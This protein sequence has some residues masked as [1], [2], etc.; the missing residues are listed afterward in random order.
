MD[1]GCAVP[2]LRPGFSETFASKLFT[3]ASVRCGPEAA[4]ACDAFAPSCRWAISAEAISAFKLVLNAFLFAELSAGNNKAARTARMAITINSSMSVNARLG[5]FII[6]LS[7]RL[8][9][10][11]IELRA[12]PL[13]S[14]DQGLFWGFS[15]NNWHA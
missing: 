6:H 12:S 1:S 10:F 5:S 9:N 7:F 15:K 8:W 2:T 11:T 4:A 14:D 13:P 3:V